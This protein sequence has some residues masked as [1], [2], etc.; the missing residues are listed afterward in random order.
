MQGDG[1]MRI[2]KPIIRVILIATLIIICNSCICHAAS[3][4]LPSLGGYE[5]KAQGGIIIEATKTIL[6]IIIA[7]GAILI[8]VFIALTGFGMI[9]GSAEEKAV[10]KE[11]FAGYLIAAI[12]LTGGATIAKIIINVAETFK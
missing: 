9:L 4:K 5:P 1:E 12:I 8:T 2:N 3:G 10:A 11:K 6:G 7:V